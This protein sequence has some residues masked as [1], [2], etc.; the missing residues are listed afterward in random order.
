[1]IREPGGV[2]APTV[3]ADLHASGAG[4]QLVIAGYT[5]SYAV[6]LILGPRLLHDAADP[7]IRRAPARR[8]RP[9]AGAA[10]PCPVWCC[11]R[12]PCCSSRCRWCSGRSGAGRC[13]A[14][15]RWG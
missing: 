7:P 9:L 6:L 11:S 1:M 15:S 3:R 12:R 13:G 5:I 8:A 2:F 14:G 10:W 4:L